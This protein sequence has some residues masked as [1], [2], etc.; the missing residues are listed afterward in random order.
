MYDKQVDDI[1]ST[2]TRLYNFYPLKPHFYTVKLGFRDLGFLIHIV[3]FVSKG[4]LFDI[5][6]TGVHIIFSYFAENIDCRFLLEPHRR[7]GSNEY[8][9]SMFFE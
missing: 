1:C 4:N 2:K 8:T 5:Y 3:F 6:F 7:D 9:Q